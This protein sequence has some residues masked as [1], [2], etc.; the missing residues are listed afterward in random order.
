MISNFIKIIENASIQEV[1]DLGK[2]KNPTSTD[3]SVS[4]SIIDKLLQSKSI[5]TIDGY[6]V[7]Q[8]QNI[9]TKTIGLE[10]N[11]EIIGYFSYKE[12]TVC[13]LYS[14]VEEFDIFVKNEERGK[15]IGKL[16]IDAILLD[17]D[18]VL[19]DSSH[20]GDNIQMWKSL[21]NRGKYNFYLYYNDKLYSTNDPLDY[22]K[23]DR[24]A[25]QILISKLPLTSTPLTRQILSDIHS[26][27]I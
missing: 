4:N 25:I 10:K 21:I 23:N 27:I 22:W 12:I 2:R 9:S 6:N 20:Y 13:H 1:N 7:K 26:G 16:L 19:S 18:I 15:G 24:G 11:Q 3:I 8:I 14:A 5:N 17:E